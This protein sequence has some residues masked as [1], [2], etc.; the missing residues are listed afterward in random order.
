MGIRILTIDPGLTATGFCVFSVKRGKLVVSELGTIRP[1]ARTFEHKVRIICSELK[2]KSSD[3]VVIEEPSPNW[4]RFGK[5]HRSL[6]LLQQLITRIV[7]NLNDREIHF[8]NADE[9]SKPRKRDYDDLQD[10]GVKKYLEGLGFKKTSRHAR[11][12]VR[13]GF[14]WTG[15]EILSQKIEVL[16]AKKGV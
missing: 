13:I 8:V 16:N 9:I 12:A 1:K 2:G 11:D 3:V 14:H 4:T 10:F 7:L 6:M 15:L 5:N